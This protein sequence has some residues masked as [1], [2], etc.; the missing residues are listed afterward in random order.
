M[1]SLNAANFSLIYNLPIYFQSIA[2]D[3]PLISGVK[4]IP[5]ILS[6]SLSTVLSSSLVGRVNNYQVFL[7]VGAVLVTIG[8]GLIYTFGFD[9]ALGQVIGYQIL[10]GVGTGL[11][12]QIPVIVAGATSTASDSA[13][14]LST[15]LCELHSHLKHIIVANIPRQS[16]SSSLPPTELARRM[17]C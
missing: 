13:V 4:V 10:Y 16:F 12:V 5:T 1:C 17:P 3:S 8:S 2:G 11:S 15:V 9:T 6:T 14:T 7:L